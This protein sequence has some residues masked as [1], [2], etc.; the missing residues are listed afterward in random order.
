MTTHEDDALSY[1]RF[2][3]DS[4]PS[5]Y[6]LNDPNFWYAS[7][8]ASLHMFVKESST[9]VKTMCTVKHHYYDPEDHSAAGAAKPAGLVAAHV[10][11]ADYRSWKWQ[12]SELTYL[13]R[14]KKSVELTSVPCRP[15]RE[16]EIDVTDIVTKALHAPHGSREITFEVTSP[17]AKVQYFSRN[18]PEEYKKP[19]LNIALFPTGAMKSLMDL[20]QHV[21]I[22]H[23]D[24]VYYRMRERDHRN[25][26]ES[27]NA[28]SLYLEAVTWIVAVVTLVGQLM[29]FQRLLK[30]KGGS[31]AV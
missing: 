16:F 22:A 6:Y 28:S 29:F 15:G 11:K 18:A 19:H 31:S 4:I 30:N 25:T 13:N 12:E 3:L 5:E 10:E 14:P 23:A 27:A 2:D 9:G 8:N 24:Q 17:H 7:V 26:V 1:V 21:F 20:S